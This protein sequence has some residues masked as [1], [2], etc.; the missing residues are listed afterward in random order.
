MINYAC[1]FSRSETEKYFETI[2]NCNNYFVTTVKPVSG[3]PFSSREP[4]MDDHLPRKEIP[5]N[6]FP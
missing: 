3:P 5:G 2:I 6:H 1:D 4:S